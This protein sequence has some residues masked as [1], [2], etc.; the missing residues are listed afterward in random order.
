MKSESREVLAVD[1]SANNLIANNYFSGLEH[2]G[3]YLYRNCGEK[4]T[5]RH[6]PPQN[7]RIINNYFYYDRYMGGNPSIFLASRN[8]NRRYCGDDKG[9]PFGSSANDLD[10]ATGNIVAQN[11]IGKLSV[12]K[13]IIQN[14][15]PNYILANESVGQKID[16]EP[17]CFVNS[18][19][20]LTGHC[21]QFVVYLVDEQFHW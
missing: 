11:Q 19:L 13:M 12:S 7:N 5:V 21:E 17:G 14:A 8:G 6:Q 2:G 16:R 15:T 10:F 18:C 3:I 9:Y 4:G 20:D 1:G